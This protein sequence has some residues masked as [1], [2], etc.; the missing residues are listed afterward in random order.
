MRQGPETRCHIGRPVPIVAK[1]IEKIISILVLDPIA[2]RQSLQDDKSRRPT[3]RKR[4]SQLIPLKSLSRKH[5]LDAVAKS[6]LQPGGED[7]REIPL[8][9]DYP[10]VTLL[11]GRLHQKVDG[12]PEAFMV[13]PPALKYETSIF[14]VGSKS[15]CPKPSSQPLIK[16]IIK[17]RDFEAKI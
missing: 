7:G 14:L 16:T 4:P 13:E 2:K 12:E 15:G 11:F 17:N 1:N 3:Y 8:Y 9:V 5:H 6:Q 10:L